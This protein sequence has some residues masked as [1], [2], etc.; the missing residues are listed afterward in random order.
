M[1]GALNLQFELHSY[2]EQNRKL[3][4]SICLLTL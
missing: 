1:E 2:T 4:Y 3:N